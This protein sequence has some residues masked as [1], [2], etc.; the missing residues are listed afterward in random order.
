MESR[1][2]QSGAVGLTKSLWVFQVNLGIG[3]TPPP[4][5]TDEIVKKEDI[6]VEGDGD[7]HGD[8][9]VAARGHTKIQGR[10]RRKALLA[11]QTWAPE[12]YVSL[13]DEYQVKRYRFC[14]S[15]FLNKP[16]SRSPL[17][18]LEWPQE[19]THC[20]GRARLR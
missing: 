12:S 5:T 13:P 8:A 2:C 1:R 14:I 9:A 7:V 16:L 11:P 17:T 18:Y 20:Q 10:K 19:K 15:Y 6:K 3:W 4:I